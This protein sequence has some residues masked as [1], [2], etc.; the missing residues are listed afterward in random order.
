MSHTPESRTIDVVVRT[1]IYREGAFTAE[2]L[3][4]VAS[5][6]APTLQR[7]IRLGLIETETASADRFTPTTATRL[8]R[9]LRLHRQLHVGLS[10]AAV[11]VD[12][13]ERL[14]RMEAELDRLRSEG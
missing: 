9:M 5:I 8:V 14:E 7:L 3:A 12:L 1:T 4:D 13:L 6:S 10:G 2:E 11:I